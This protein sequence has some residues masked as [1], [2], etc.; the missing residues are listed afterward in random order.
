MKR[1]RLPILAAVSAAG[2]LSLSVP[3]ALFAQTAPGQ[4]ASPAQPA[5]PTP[6][7]NVDDQQLRSFAKVYVQVEKI[8]QTYEPRAKQ[9][10]GPEEGK[11]I[12]QEA[13]S[14][15][16][17]A[18]TKEGLTEDKYTQIFEVARADQDVR[19]KVL[20]MINEEKGKS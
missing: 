2:F 6:P 1:V 18:L 4:A 9:A 10:S 12:Q 20:Q 5:N 16:Q 7:A 3:T 19:K 14:K 11:Q 8:R 13:Q 17:D 15:F